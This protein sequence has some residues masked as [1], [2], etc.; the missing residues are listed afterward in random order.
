MRKRIATILLLS[1]VV[2]LFT[3]TPARAITYGFNAITANNV[4][5]VATG[6]AQLFMDVTDPGGGSVLFT[7]RNTGPNPCSIC[8][9]YFYDG[10][11][12]GATMS[13]QNSSGVAFSPNANP[14]ALPG[15]IPYG[16]PKASVVFSAD[17]DSGDPGVMT[18][19]VNPGESLG[20]QFA[21]A[22]GKSFA[23]VIA[24]LDEGSTVVGIHVQS[25]GHS[26]SESFVNVPLPPSVLLL[27][28]G[29][30]GLGLRGFR[31]RRQS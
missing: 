29:L 1:G 23:E 25:F 3:I 30:V 26:G 16:L 24:T 8:D 19:G 2:L 18:N 11:L 21:L 31:R 9:V 13:I 12:L 15:G 28:S 4:A 10:A 7:F 6:E 14:E 27:G 20:I 22:S 5:D 17:S